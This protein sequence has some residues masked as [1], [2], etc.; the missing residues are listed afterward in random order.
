MSREVVAGT[1][2]RYLRS[3]RWHRLCGG[4]ERARSGEAGQNEGGGPYCGRAR[5]GYD[6]LG[7]RCRINDLEVAETR[8]RFASLLL[9][10][11]AKHNEEGGRT[12]RAG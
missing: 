12:V 5:H 6:Y 2:L 9:S 7:T 1:A 11:M 8:W 3:W 4:E 10:D